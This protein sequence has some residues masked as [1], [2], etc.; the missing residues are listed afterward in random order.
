MAV[1]R[2]ARC[3]VDPADAEAMLAERAALVAAIRDAVPGLIQGRHAK[4]D[5]K[6][7]IDVWHWDWRTS[8]QTATA[9]AP[10][11]RRQCS[12]APAL[13]QGGGRT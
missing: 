2:L 7:W 11:Q 6:T 3:T 12:Q 5:D 1:L 13:W 9:G 10:V 8:A 4:V